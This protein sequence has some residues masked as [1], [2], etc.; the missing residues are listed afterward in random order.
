M[1]RRRAFSPDHDTLDAQA[2]GEMAQAPEVKGVWFLTARRH[3]VAV[4]GDAK[5]HAVAR[6]LSETTRPMLLEPMPSAWYGED[7]FREMMSA[8]MTEL[9]RGDTLAFSTFMEECTVLG[10]NTFFRILLRIT[11]VEFL[12]RK[13]PTL[14]KQYRRNDSI[15]TVDANETRAV[16]RWENFPFFDDRNYR[17]FTLATLIKTAEMCT[18]ARPKGDVIEHTRDTMT[19]QVI[20]R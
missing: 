1:Q 16:L 20:Y 13:M 11:S 4:H 9:C 10:V 2:Q 3:I 15:C 12:M 19:V 8:V 7:V 18:G 14:S 5:L 6:A 17:L